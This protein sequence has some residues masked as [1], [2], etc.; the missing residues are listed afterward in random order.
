[1]SSKGKPVS[2]GLSLA[3]S[4]R[5]PILRV[6]GLVARAE[7]LGFGSAFVIDS[8]MAVKDAYVTLAAAALRTSRIQLGTGVT[9]P[10]TRD[11][12][13]T[14]SSF[15]ALQEVSGGRAILGL[16]NGATSVEAVGL[17]GANLAGTR[18]A[19]LKLRGLLDGQRV[20]HN[21]VEVRMPATAARVPILLS[22]SRPRMLG[23]AGEVADGAIV[24]SSAKAR[25]VQEQLDQ[26]GGGLER[27][28]RPRADFRLD[29]W[30]T[31]SVRED[32]AQAVEDVK[33]WVAS[34]LVW[35][36]ARAESVPPEIAAAIDWEKAR[37]ATEAYDITEHLSLHARHR[38]LVTDEL[39]DVLAIA[40]DEEHAIGRLSE[41]AELDVDGITLALLSG[42]REE[43]LET[44]GRIIAEVTR[45][46][47]R[48][49]GT[50]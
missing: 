1:M 37:A 11:L 8:Q 47:R 40:G 43:R 46:A 19:I 4:Q 3:A 14:A 20:Q 22:A 34:Q 7:E 21:G 29:L 49:A 9:N 33:S 30:Q 2:F 12:T 41:L 50:L 26:V 25:L 36:L 23:L 48:P 13:V 42:G 31:I 28:G 15:A 39:V 27:S 44:L 5:E 10:I 38:E 35:W 17:K 6:A 18:E 24:M 32:R 45:R 16:G